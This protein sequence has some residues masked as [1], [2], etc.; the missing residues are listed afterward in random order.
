M[1]TIA[2][3]PVVVFTWSRDHK[4][5][6]SRFEGRIVGDFPDEGD[7]AIDLR[8]GGQTFMRLRY[9]EIL[10]IVPLLNG[11]DVHRVA[12]YLRIAQDSKTDE[13]R[14]PELAAKVAAISIKPQPGTNLACELFQLHLGIRL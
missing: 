10:A 13:D 8:T 1:S 7:E 5:P 3:I 9:S 12:G 2:D 11:D 6:F 4:A 14:I